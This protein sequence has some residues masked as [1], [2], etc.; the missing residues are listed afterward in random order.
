[1][2][3]TNSECVSVALVIQH[4]QR[5]LRIILSSMACLALPYFSTFSHKCHDFRQN[6]I[7]HK[8]VFSFSIQ[9]LSKTV[10]ILGQIQRDTVINVYRSSCKVLVILVIFHET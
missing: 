2:S 3:S 1:M 6:V 8:N 5:M 10:L 9:L 4:A 7:E